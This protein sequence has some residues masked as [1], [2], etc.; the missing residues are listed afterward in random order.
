MTRPDIASLLGLNPETVS[1]L[2]TRFA[3]RRLVRVRGR[4]VTILDRDSL[5]ALF[6]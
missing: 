2:F 4:E 5:Q 3:A 1:R 6:S